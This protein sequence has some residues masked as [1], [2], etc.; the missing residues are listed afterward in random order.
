MDVPSLRL[1]MEASRWV[2]TAAAGGLTII[3]PY[4]GRRPNR[5]ER[6]SEKLHGRVGMDGQHCWVGVHLEAY[7][8]V[9]GPPTP[10]DLLMLTQ[11]HRM[12]VLEV[13]LERFEF[14]L[15]L[16]ELHLDG[17]SEEPAGVAG[18]W[19]FSP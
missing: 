8:Q 13:H 16:R 3:V 14:R 5:V 11:R 1:R 18:H 4:F 2:W 10:H 17:E 19:P 9:S 7:R 15:E 12:R 6:S